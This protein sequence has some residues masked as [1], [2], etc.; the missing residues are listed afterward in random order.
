MM[1]KAPLAGLVGGGMGFGYHLMM[2][3]INPG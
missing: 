1:W 2:T 3:A